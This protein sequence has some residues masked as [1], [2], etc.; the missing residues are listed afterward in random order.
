MFHSNLTRVRTVSGLAGL[1]I[2]ALA[3]SGCAAAA[4]AADTTADTATGE[5]TTVTVGVLAIAPSVAMQYGIDEGIF[6]KHGLDVQLQTGQGGAAMLPA[7][8]AGSMDFAIGNPLSVMVAVDKGLEMQIVTGYSNSKAEGDDI[9]GVVVRTDSGIDSFADLEDQTVS[10]NA[11]STQGD[12]TIKESAEIDGADPS[13]I[14]FNE[15]PFPDMEAQL[16]AGNTDAIW[17]PEPFLS[18]ALASSDFKLIGYPNQQALP[19]LPTMVTFT[20]AK[21]ATANAD[22]LAKFREAVDET[23]AAAEANPDDVRATLPAFMGMD[24]GVAEN[25]KMETFNGDVPADVLADLGDLMQ[26][27]EIVTK[28]PNV[29][30]MIAS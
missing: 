14:N 11:V 22:T 30:A 20:S 12:L 15:M 16:A 29:S 26:K 25:M 10:V 21:Y 8:Y 3:L 18:K 9:N 5:L 1:A 19:G 23:L 6:E 27:Y 24:A 7:V 28:A 2:V 4:P 13:L 17:L